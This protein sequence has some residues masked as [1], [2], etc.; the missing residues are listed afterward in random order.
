MLVGL[1]E[2]C[3]GPGAKD[4]NSLTSLLAKL[5]ISPAVLPLTYSSNNSP[6]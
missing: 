4:A 1:S 6:K 2:P 3:W 5:G